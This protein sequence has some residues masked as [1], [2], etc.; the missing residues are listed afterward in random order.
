MATLTP[1]RDPEVTIIEQGEL[2]IDEAV[3][4]FAGTGFKDRTLTVPTGKL[5]VIKGF[6]VY[7]G[8]TATVGT[9]QVLLGIGGL[10]TT[11]A[12]QASPAAATTYLMTYPFPLTLKAGNTL[13]FLFN[14]VA[15][16]NGNETTRALYVELDA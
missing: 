6:E 8:G 12:A 5:W 15:D 7:Q 4:T 2:K 9:A 10:S 11:I 14:V 16:T 3:I 1:N 13:R